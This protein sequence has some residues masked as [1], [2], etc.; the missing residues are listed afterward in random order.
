MKYTIVFSPQADLDMFD[1]ESYIK[2]DLQLPNTA[3]NYMAGLDNTIDHLA[4]YADTVGTNSYV[5][6]MF[7]ENARRI[8]YKKMVIIF[9]IEGD[10][11]Y[12][13]RVIAGSMIH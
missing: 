11:V 9:Y 5:Q 3:I 10:C 4:M 2:N 8:T 13:E 7:G 6:A 1:L 12:I